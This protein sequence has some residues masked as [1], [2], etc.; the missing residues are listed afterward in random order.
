MY[1]NKHQG[2]TI[3]EVLV[4][5]PIVILALG[6]FIAVMVNMTAEV[7]KTQSEN[8]MVQST[9]DALNTIEQDIKL[10]GQ[11][12]AANELTAQSPQG[13]ADGQGPI[14][15]ASDANSFTNVTT[16]DTRSKMLIL[17][18]FTTDKNP[19]DGTRQPIYTDQPSG[20]C[21]QK[22][23]NKLFSSN[24][25]YFVKNNTLWKRTIIQQGSGR[26]NLCLDSGQT[27]WQQPSCSSTVSKGTYCK[28]NDTRLA[29]NVSDFTVDY[30]VNP[31]DTTPIATAVDTT[32]TITER[33]D[34]LSN[35][36]AVK[37]NIATSTTVAGREVSNSASMRAT[38]LNITSDPPVV[39]ALG[40]TQQPVD[41]YVIPADGS[42]TF[43]ATSNISSATYQWQI[44]TTGA[45]GP[46]LPVSNGAN[47]S[48]ATTSTLTVSN[49][50]TSW[51]GTAYTGWNGYKYRA[52]ITNFGDQA[53]SNVATL[54]VSNWGS[55]T[56]LNGFGHYQDGASGYPTIG[57]TKTSAGV[58]MLRGM[59]EKSSAI[60]AG[61]IIGVLPDGYK[62]NGTLIFQTSTSANVPSRVDVNALGEIR[63]ESGS[64]S[65]TSLEGISFIPAGTSHTRN[66]LTPTSGWVNWGNPFS[67]ASYATDSLGRTHTQGLLRNGTIADGTQLVNNLS[68]AARSPE[69]LHLPARSNTASGIGIDPTTGI[70]AKG[71]GSSSY[72]SINSMFYPTSFPP[73]AGTWTNLSLMSSWIPYG[74]FSSP[75]YIKGSDNIVRLKGLI[76]GGSAA[77]GVQV[78]LMPTGYRPKER[79]LTTALC[80]PQ[81]YCRIDVLPT[82]EVLMY[83]SNSGWTALDNITFLAEQ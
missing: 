49:F 14:N 61:D 36:S 71:V 81:V 11:F 32:K 58:V 60:V 66:T 73:A 26:P 52:V 22:T 76:K 7:L 9:Q 75:Q 64:Q 59:V 54:N 18:T 37:V 45:S 8:S 56:Y 12:L 83:L 27:V 46:W 70:V 51:N 2:F 62:P 10:S 50:T 29:N 47:Y 35:A 1:Q 39:V 4:I 44:S 82:G 31:G 15:S 77:Y 53:T 48:G 20:N 43:T 30:F 57:Y 69:Y 80:N 23:V 55:V 38:K 24:T 79:T 17:R 25:I 33:N 40:F 6:A 68:A 34:A 16:G 3:V 41:R 72:L 42:T 78:A 65:W 28:V 5:A 13:Y 21:D 67:T 19:I 74:G 63:I